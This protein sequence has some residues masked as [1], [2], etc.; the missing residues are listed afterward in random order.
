VV[1]GGFVPEEYAARIQAIVDEYC[2]KT[3]IEHL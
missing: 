1:A 2:Q 3:G